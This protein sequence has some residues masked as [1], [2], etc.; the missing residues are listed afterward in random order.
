M[1]VRVGAPHFMF[2]GEANLKVKGLNTCSKLL[3]QIFLY[4]WA[5]ER[6]DRFDTV[7]GFKRPTGRK[8]RSGSEKE[9]KIEEEEA[10]KP[11]KV[12]QRKRSNN[13]LLGSVNSMLGTPPKARSDSLRTI[14][15]GKGSQLLVKP[16]K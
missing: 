8:E 5:N 14:S 2:Y 3:F 13:S 12:V 6:L 4:S 1:T 15:S 7:S 11:K 16:P 10:K 9:A